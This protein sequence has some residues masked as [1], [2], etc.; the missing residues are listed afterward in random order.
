MSYQNII[1]ASVAKLEAQKELE[2][3]ETARIA[4]EQAQALAAYQIEA[5]R[6]AERIIHSD[7]V[8]FLIVT[9][10][11]THWGYGFSLNIPGC[12]PI[13]FQLERGGKLDGK[14]TT[15]NTPELIPGEDDGES[16][17]HDTGWEYYKDLEIAIAH[18]HKNFKL[19][20]EYNQ[21]IEYDRAQA[22]IK[23]SQAKLEDPA[24]RR[25]TDA[26]VYEAL[27]RQDYMAV[28]QLCQWKYVS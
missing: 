9:T 18:A 6:L 8:E 19:E 22:A 24:D 28:I 15:K 12:N 13:L 7:L 17:T 4:A 11:K 16:W 2:A 26:D 5:I 14:F 25:R 1:A 10:D 27:D 3:L 23:A 21:T 20:I